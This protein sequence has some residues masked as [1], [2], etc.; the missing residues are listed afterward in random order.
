M[1][2]YVPQIDQHLKKNSTLAPSPPPPPPKLVLSVLI[3]KCWQ[4]WTTPNSIVHTFVCLPLQT[5]QIQV[6][7]KRAVRILTGSKYNSHTE[8]L[9]KQINLLKVN[10]ICKLNEIKFYYKLVHKQQ[11]QYFNSFTHEANSDIHGH[12]TRSRNE[13]HFP[14]TKH[15]FAKINLRYRILQTINELPETVTRKVYTHSIKVVVA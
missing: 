14:K 12:D 1:C 15:D 8:P 5:K 10:D 3:G 13:L 6:I 7:Q 11:P 4:L 2:W 9:F